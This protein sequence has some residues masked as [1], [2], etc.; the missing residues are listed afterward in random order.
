MTAELP[1]AS[2]AL[3]EGLGDL[4]FIA[5]TGYSFK[6]EQGTKSQA[7]HNLKGCDFA[8]NF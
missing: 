7:A 4:T 5:N 2:L 3:G 1:L 8:A 6:G